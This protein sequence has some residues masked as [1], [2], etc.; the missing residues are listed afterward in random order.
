[1]D[2]A[3]WLFHLGRGDYSKWLREHIKDESLA[4]SVERIEQDQRQTAAATRSLVR[5]AIEERY[6]LPS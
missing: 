3:T 5:R 4:R 1:V 6:A 2:D